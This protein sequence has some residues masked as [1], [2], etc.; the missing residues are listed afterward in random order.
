MKHEKKEK[1]L[2][3]ERGSKKIA[4]RW[5]LNVSMG[6]KLIRKIVRQ[7]SKGKLFLTNFF[8]LIFS[9]SFAN[10]NLTARVLKS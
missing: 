4:Y 9:D 6:K 5:R 3:L 2:L 1:P 7:S 10:S 8:K